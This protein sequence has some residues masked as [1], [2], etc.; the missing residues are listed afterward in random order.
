MRIKSVSVPLFMTAFVLALAESCYAQAVSAPT[1]NTP[2]APAHPIVAVLPFASAGATDPEV[3]A[4]T[5]RLHE[6][7]QR[8]G[9]F[10]VA[11]QGPVNAAYQDQKTQP[12]AC[13][14]V[15]CAVGIGWALHA[16]RIVMG[17]ITRMDETHW[18]VSAQLIDVETSKSLRTNSL[19]YTGSFF[20]FVRE[21]IPFLAARLSGTVPKESRG[22]A[23]RM[24][25]TLNL[26]G[27]TQANVG[28]NEPGA[29]APA[30][31]HKGFGAFTGY[32]FSSG[33]I[34][35]KSG[36]TATY[37]GG[38]VPNLGLDY[39]FELNPQ[40]TLL[41]YFVIG[42]G[43]VTGD[44]ANFYD[45]VG[46]EEIGVEARYW[47]G[48]FYAGARA[49]LYA[50]AF[51]SVNNSPKNSSF[52]LGGESL[53]VSGGYE[54]DTGA[55]ANAALDYATFSSAKPVTAKKAA[56]APDVTLDGSGEGYTL[57]LN[58]GYRWK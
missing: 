38:G 23:L 8:I 50:L 52:A 18:L 33:S 46:A 43:S 36:G 44:M 3:S 57:W 56:S 31:R 13:V 17:K 20:D 26:S 41:P 6:E 27:E 2:A 29:S 25:E 40:V 37:A 7:L 39:Q 48:R 30:L 12:G 35:M 10:T 16:Q 32:T 15:E 24:I 58:I 34:R 42:T 19:Q 47:V 28:V 21:G 4:G 14:A 54:A 51:V 45:A 49:A 22:L 9:V 11:D 1:P 55:F 53:G 5:D